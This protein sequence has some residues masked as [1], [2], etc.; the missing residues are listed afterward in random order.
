M[1]LL[2]EFSEMVHVES[3]LLTEYHS[4]EAGQKEQINAVFLFQVF[5]QWFNNPTKCINKYATAFKRDKFLF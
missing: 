2:W 1:G 5:I 3:A 4:I